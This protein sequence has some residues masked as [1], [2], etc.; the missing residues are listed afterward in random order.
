MIAALPGSLLA[1]IPVAIAAGFVSFASPCVLPLVPGYVA[2]LGGAVGA[3]ATRGGHRAVWG[4]GAFILGFS[5][6]FVSEGALFG[7]FGHHFE[8][9]ERGLAIGFGAVTIV[10]GLFFAGWLPLGALL[11]ERRSHHLPS[12]TVG[13]AFVLGLLFS[14]GWIP[15]IGPTLGA[16]VA[17]ESSSVGATAARG[18]V[19]TCFYCAGLGVPFVI[20][21]VAGEWAARA[22]RWLRLHQVAVARIGGLLLIA[23]G[24]AEMTGWWQSF[25]T[26][27]QGLYPS[28]VPA[29]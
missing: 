17:L 25:V 12:P 28:F 3:E 27:L 5:A 10:L 29:L 16:I 1:A 2:F 20:I 15:C 18:S 23:I 8:A 21:A 26:W 24:V 11:R 7:E 22:S 13:G 19:L 14:L 9:H 4:T 6:V